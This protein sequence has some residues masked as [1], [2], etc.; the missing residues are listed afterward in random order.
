MSHNI[1]SLTSRINA[2]CGRSFFSILP[3]GNSH[4]PG[5]VVDPPLC[6]HNILL[7][8]TIT[9]PT[10]CIVF[11]NWIASKLS[12]FSYFIVLLLNEYCYG[13]I[14]SLLSRTRQSTGPFS[15]L[16]FCSSNPLLLQE[17]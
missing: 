14:C 5:K 11:F 3:P 2:C 1:S 15:P 13:H 4:L 7:S 6:A 16:R 9:A 8:F 17:R 10:T 12:E